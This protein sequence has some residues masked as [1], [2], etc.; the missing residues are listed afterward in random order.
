MSK[1]R[2][3][4]YFSD[5]A[6][7]RGSELTPLQILQFIEDFRNLHFE[8]HIRDKSVL[9]SMKVPES[10]LRSF[11]LQAHLRGKRYQTWI[12]ELMRKEIEND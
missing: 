11:K 8:S 3:V 10:L 2:A 5:E 9:I 7:E 12:K 4:Q 6:L 1:Q